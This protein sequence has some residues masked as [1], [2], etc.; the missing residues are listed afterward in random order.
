MSLAA[1]YPASCPRVSADLSSIL[2]SARRHELTVSLAADYPASCPRVSADLPAELS[3]TWHR[4]SG[5]RASDV[6]GFN[7]AL[8]DFISSIAV[9]YG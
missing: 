5:R 6:C 1:N 4:V 7:I 3:F 8:A 9:G 2:S